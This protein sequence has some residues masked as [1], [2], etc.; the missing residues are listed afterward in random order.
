MLGTQAGA[1]AKLLSIIIKV[2]NYLFVDIKIDELLFIKKKCMS[3]LCNI[4]RNVIV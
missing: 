2:K 4:K 3:S 1:Q